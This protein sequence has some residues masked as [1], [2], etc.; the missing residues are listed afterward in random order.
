MKKKDILHPKLYFKY[1]VVDQQTQL[2]YYSNQLDSV[3][4]RLVKVVLLNQ[5]SFSS[6]EMYK[7]NEKEYHNLNLYI[8]RQERIMDTYLKKGFKDQFNIVETSVNLMYT[9]RKEFDKWF[10]KFKMDINV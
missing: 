1:D 6:I 7:L 2:S 10:S 9:F 5:N 4:S 3:G 8:E